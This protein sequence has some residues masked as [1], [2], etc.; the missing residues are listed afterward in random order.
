MEAKQTEI[1][2]L[3]DQLKRQQE[4]FNGSFERSRIG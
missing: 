4:L 1:T 3:Q 2:K